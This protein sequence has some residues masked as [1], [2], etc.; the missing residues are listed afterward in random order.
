MSITLEM[1]ITGYPKVLYYH[2][3]YHKLAMELHQNSNAPLI[4]T[5]YPRQLN[6]IIFSKSK[7]GQTPMLISHTMQEPLSLEASLDTVLLIK[8]VT[9]VLF[10]LLGCAA[11]LRLCWSLTPRHPPTHQDSFFACYEHWLTAWHFVLRQMCGLQN[12]HVRSRLF[13]IASVSS[14]LILK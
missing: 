9:R 6:N 13:I 12:T 7:R 2:S 11:G 1:I 4:L 5:L 8:Q 10:S 14:L 3:W